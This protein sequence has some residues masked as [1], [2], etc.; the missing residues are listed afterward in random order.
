MTALMYESTKKNGCAFKGL[1]G[2]M[3]VEDPE[4]AEVV[5]RSPGNSAV[6]ENRV[7]AEPCSWSRKA[8]NKKVDMLTQ[9]QCKTKEKEKH[10]RGVKKVNS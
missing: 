5:E 9:S 4:V 10:T 7:G 3:R 8:S 6:V 1:S 2:V